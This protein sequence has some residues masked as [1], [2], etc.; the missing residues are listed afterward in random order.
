MSIRILALFAQALIGLLAAGMLFWKDGLLSGSLVSIAVIAA[1]LCTWWGEQGGGSELGKLV[2]MLEAQDHADLS[3]RLPRGMGD[4]DRIARSIDGFRSELSQTLKRVRNNNVALSIEAARIGKEMRDGVGHAQAQ[5]ELADSI[6]SLTARSSTEVVQ[7]EASIGVI[8]EQAQQ[9]AHSA[10]ATRAEM[11]AANRDAHAAA[12]AMDGFERSISVLLDETQSIIGSVDEIRS[13]ADQTNLLALNAAIEAARAGEAGRGF[14][15]VADEVRKLAERTRH[16]SDAVTTKA[17]SIHSQSRETSTAAGDA[18]RQIGAAG[19]VLERATQQLNEF[20]DG[21]MRVNEE[22]TAINVAVAALSTNNRAIHG[23]VGNLQAHARDIADRLNRSDKV[24]GQLIAAAERVMAELGRFRLGDY[25]M[26][27][28]LDRLR[29]AKDECESMCNTL[30][31]EG[32]DLFDKRFQQIP[33]TDPAQYHTSYDEAFEKRFQSYYDKLV[34]EVKGCD[35]AVIC[36]GDEAYPPTHVSKYC[37]PQ[38]AGETAWNTAHCRD[39]RF[40]KANRMLHRTSTDASPFLFQA[41]VRDVG[42]I[43]GL[44]SVPIYVRGRHWGGLMFAIEQSALSAD[45]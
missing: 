11:D 40:H 12:S 39:K 30:A 18:A 31:A 9:L 7:V 36:V 10:Q 23:H 29:R 3:L 20:A 42:D 5:A 33:G 15:V 35:L 22:V 21:A 6:F 37:Q 16:L 28:I 14:A 1:A 24:A 32:R 17:Q 38:K 27:R 19:E 41:Y 26:D 34:Q 13:I 25:A 45:E 2:K 8:A 44:F 4:L 43:F